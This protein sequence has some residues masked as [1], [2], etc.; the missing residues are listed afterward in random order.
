MFTYLDEALRSQVGNVPSTTN[1]IEGGINSQLRA[2]L[3]DHR[4]LSVERRIKAVF[5]WCYMHSPRPLSATE[6]LKVMPSDKSISDI[7]N[8]MSARGQLEYSIP[9]WGDAVVWSDLHRSSKYPD[10][11]S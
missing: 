3:R 10:L 9:N 6:L 5:W 8:R 2:M 4:G 7:Y 11:W 1:M